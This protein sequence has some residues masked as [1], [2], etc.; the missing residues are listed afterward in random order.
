MVL[1]AAVALAAPQPTAATTFYTSAEL[2]ASDRAATPL[3]SIAGKVYNVA[4]LL[5]SHPGG[6][7]V[8][9]ALLGRDATDV[10]LNSHPD[11]VAALLPSL[12][13]GSLSDHA[14]DPATRDYRALRAALQAEGAFEPNSSAA[15]A[16]YAAAGARAAA[17]LAAALGCVLGSA[18]WGAHLLGGALLGAFWQQLAF[19]GHDLGHNGVSGVRATDM[20]RGLLFGPALTGI[21]FSWWKSTHNAHHV[22]TNSATNDPDVQY[23]PLLAVSA[24]AFASP[25][26]A[27]HKKRL[28][29]GG[30]A[31]AAVASQHVFFYP[32]MF[33]ARWNLYFQGVCGLV[34]GVRTRA[35]AAEAGALCF[36]FAWVGA[37]VAAVGRGEG[38]LVAALAVRAGFLLL[39]NGVAGALHVQIVLSHFSQPT[40]PGRSADGAGSFLQRQFAATLNVSLPPWADFSFGGLQWQVEHHLFPRLPAH[41]LR[42]VAP[43]VRALAAAHGFPYHT[44]TFSEA[45]ARLYS[46]LRRTAAEAEKLDWRA[47]DARV[48]DA[49][50]LDALALRG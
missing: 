44:A 22:D 29:F 41:A 27:Y 32:L 49:R 2:A 11:H 12:C 19:I 28:S 4:P 10:F 35:A 31:R 36:F 34:L 25:W 9:A 50:L 43:R 24:H 21:S 13:V 6:P 37:L 5:A 47:L 33:F 39:C 30:C 8:L 42:G 15:R 3:L 17:L 23:A 26:S 14:V 46:T 20:A 16:Y 18:H 7:A 40:V 38:G 45:N 48:L 1:N